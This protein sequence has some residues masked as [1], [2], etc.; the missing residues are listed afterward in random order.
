[1][2]RVYLEYQGDS[3]ELPVGET[4]IGRDVTC[5]L[6]FNDPS[7]SRRHLRFV[8]RH[9][10]VFVQDLGSTNGSTLNGKAVSGPI[11]VE[12]GDEIL[13]GNRKVTMHFGEGEKPEDTLSQRDFSPQRELDKLRAATTRIAVTVPPP[14]AA[15]SELAHRRHERTRH[16][17][18]LVYVSDELEI[19]A[20][21]RDLSMSGVFVCTQV[22]DPIGTRCQLAILIDG[23]PPLKLSAVVRRVVEHDAIGG[24]GVEFDKVGASERVWLEKTIEKLSAA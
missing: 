15:A 21:T 9:D 12:D 20:T 18:Q 13:L 3:I 5:S 17:L 6:R 11:M 14:V 23:G 19:E 24:M 10:T 16:S 22:L 2:S 7:V 8:R 4:V 1:V